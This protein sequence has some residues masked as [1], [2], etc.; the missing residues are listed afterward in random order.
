MFSIVSSSFLIKIFLSSPFSIIGKNSIII[1]P[2]F[3]T[4]EFFGQNKPE[5]KATGITSEFSSRIVM[6]NSQSSGE[7]SFIVN[8][9]SAGINS[10]T[11]ST[12][13][14]TAPHTIETGETV[15]VISTNGILPDGEESNKVNYAIA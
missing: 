4:K 7:K 9:S 8:R 15:R 3:I 13:T 2:G 11:S 6:P 10:I 12:M 14:L 5:F 1:L